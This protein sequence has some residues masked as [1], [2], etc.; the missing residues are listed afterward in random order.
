MQGPKGAGYKDREGVGAA[1]VCRFRKA[2]LV[3][4][5]IG[6][7]CGLAGLQRSST[8]CPGG[9]HKHAEGWWSIGVGK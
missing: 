6:S 3:A 7:V 9:D 1:K 5:E 8:V 2:S 4:T